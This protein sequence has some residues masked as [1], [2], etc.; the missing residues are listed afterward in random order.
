MKKSLQVGYSAGKPI[1][2]AVYCFNEINLKLKYLIFHGVTGAIN[3][4]FFD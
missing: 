1:G 2:S 4:T 3:D